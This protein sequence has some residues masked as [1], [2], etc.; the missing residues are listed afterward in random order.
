MNAPAAIATD[1]VTSLY[2]V[3]EQQRETIAKQHKA[4]LDLLCVVD[5]EANRRDLEGRD[6]LNLRALAKRVRREL[7]T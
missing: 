1:S 3:Y 6:A 2:R 5:L 4:I 7:N